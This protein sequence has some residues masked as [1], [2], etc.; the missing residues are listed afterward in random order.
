LLVENS[1]AEEDAGV[2]KLVTQILQ[3]ACS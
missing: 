2:Q 1:G 3:L